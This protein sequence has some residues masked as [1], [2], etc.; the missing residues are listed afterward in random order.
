MPAIA[1]GLSRNTFL[2]TYE[3]PCGTSQRFSQSP[4][5]QKHEA[6]GQEIKEEQVVE[7]IDVKE[8]IESDGG[9]EQHAAG[10]NDTRGGD[11]QHTMHYQEGHQGCVGI[12]KENR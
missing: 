5:T 2:S 12:D 11:A 7:E 4:E 3:N 8:E 10:A 9:I 6:E 1:V